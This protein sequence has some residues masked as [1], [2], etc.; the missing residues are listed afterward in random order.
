MTVCRSERS[1]L[2]GRQ[3]QNRKSPTLFTFFVVLLEI[4]EHLNV[5]R[6]LLSRSHLAGVTEDVVGDQFVAT[7][8][9]PLDD[10]LLS[11]ETGQQSQS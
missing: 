9:L 1:Q 2:L 10:E 8:R 6:N 11:P 7:A 5:T 4:L 3:S